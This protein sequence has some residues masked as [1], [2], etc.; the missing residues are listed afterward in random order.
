[1]IKI[2]LNCTCGRT[3]DLSGKQTDLELRPTEKGIRITKKCPDCGI[4]S[5]VNLNKETIVTVQ[6]VD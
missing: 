4:I 5:S 3:E 1:M 2:K 6:I